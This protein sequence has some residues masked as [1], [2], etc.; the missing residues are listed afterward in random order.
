MLMP[1][2]HRAADRGP[3][4]DRRSDQVRTWL[5]ETATRPDRIVYDPGSM[6]R[7]CCKETAD[8]C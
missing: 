7:V 3:T 1:Q 4:P 5:E 6:A 2:R 8:A